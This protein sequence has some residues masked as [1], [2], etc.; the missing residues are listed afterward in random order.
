MTVFFWIEKNS[1]QKIV[2]YKSD[3]QGRTERQ[4]RKT[5]Q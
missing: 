1:F 5:D 2:K 4:K 3:K